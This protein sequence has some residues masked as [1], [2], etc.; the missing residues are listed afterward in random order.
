[1]AGHCPVVRRKQV[2]F[3]LSLLRSASKKHNNQEGKLL[4]QRTIYYLFAE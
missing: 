2:P 1:M 4:G 3:M